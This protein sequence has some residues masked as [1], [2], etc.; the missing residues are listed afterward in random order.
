MQKIINELKEK[1]YYTMYTVLRNKIEKECDKLINKKE[2]IP[3][4]LIKMLNNL[5]PSFYQYQKILKYEKHNKIL[6]NPPVTQSFNSILFYNICTTI[7]ISNIFLIK[8]LFFYIKKNY[9]KEGTY[10]K[11]MFDFLRI[12]ALLNQNK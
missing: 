9:T 1:K 6:Q 4:Y 11:N 3:K 12:T 8:A 2:I 7:F 5:R 10:I